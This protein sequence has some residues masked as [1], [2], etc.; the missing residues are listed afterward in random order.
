MSI[1]DHRLLNYGLWLLPVCWLWFRL[2]DHLRVEWLVNAQY[3]Y[4]WAVPFMCAYLIWRN[5]G[6]AIGEVRSGINSSRQP[7]ASDGRKS[8]FQISTPV[9]Y[10]LFV[11]GALLY[12]PTRL[13]EEANPE[14]RLV[15]WALAI[16]VVGITLLFA[17]A[18]AANRSRYKDGRSKAGEEEGTLPISHSDLR[19]MAFAICFFLVAV[20]WPTVIEAPLIQS[21]TRA[22]ATITVE[23]M[24][25]WGVPAM[26]RGNVIEITT[27]VV[28][29]D[30]ACSGIRSFQAA[31][32]ISLFLGEL[33]LLNWLQRLGLVIGGF[34]MSFVFN[35]GRTALLVW[36]ASRKGVA[37]ISSWHD[38]AG[39][40]IL[41]CCFF[42]LW[43]LAV[44]LKKSKNRD[45]DKT[46]D[47]PTST[48]DPL[49]A[50]ISRPP[51]QGLRAA[52]FALVAWL[53]VVEASVEWWYRAHEAR[54]A[55]KVVWS[56]NLPEQNPTLR[57]L[58]M[59][60]AAQRILRYDEAVNASWEDHGRRFQVI[61]L[62]W[63]AGRTALH[64]AK[65]HTPEVCLTAAGR[66]LAAGSNLRQ[67]DV[68][69]LRLPFRRYDVIDEGQP[70]YVFYCLWD[71][72]AGEQSF[73]TMALDYGNRFGPVLAGRRNPGQRSLEI[74]VSGIADAELAAN[75]IKTELEKLVVVK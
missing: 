37:A 69:G 20:P 51:I 67:L 40:V 74:A 45:T 39:V 43:V 36:V 27:G 75:T 71:D 50:P 49:P 38:P 13:I 2:I 10:L 57:K 35:V 58:S 15:S 34:I 7:L 25:L 11:L 8:C 28:G 68:C 9:F 4:G 18:T 44:R 48:P 52:C 31:L 66:K 16:G 61:F 3:G 41:L 72:L 65:S 14:W 54:L 47:C 59:S 63:N 12:A 5:A 21:L 22:N 62:R 19:S 42:G 64:L 55:T 33:Y 46:A 1:L 6:V 24:R 70:L 32:M 23:L 53:L 17:Y 73:D 56:V 26:Q 60:E 29:I 30:E